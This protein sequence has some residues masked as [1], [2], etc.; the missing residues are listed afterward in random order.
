MIPVKGEPRV[1]LAKPAKGYRTWPFANDFMRHV[2]RAPSSVYPTLAAVLGSEGVTFYD[3]VFERKSTVAGVAKLAAQF[4]VVALGLVSSVLSLDMEVQI[5]AIKRLAPNTKIVL[6]GHQPTFYA[7]DWIARGVDAIIRSEGEISFPQVVDRFLAGKEPGGI[8]GVTWRMGEQAV[9]EPDCEFVKKLDDLPLPDW[10]VIDL[11]LYDLGLAPKGLT[12]T[13]ETARG[14]PHR[15]VFCASAAMWRNRQRFKSVERVMAEVRNLHERG[16]RQI[17]IADDNFGVY[18]ERDLE[19]FAQLAPLDVHLWAFVRADTIYHDREWAE[20][21]AKAG[22]R[23]ALIGFENLSEKM[24]AR[25]KKEQKGDLGLAEYQE[26]YR[27]LKKGGAFV[28]GLFVR[29]FDFSADDAW[30]AR[31]IATVCDVSAQSRF[32]PMRGVPG[33]EALVAQGYDLKDMFYH[34][35]FWPSFT[36]AGKVQS[37]HFVGAL[38]YDLLKPR[39]FFK[40]F[41]GSYVERVFFRRLYGG[42][43][44][45]F[46]RISPVRLKAAWIASRRRLS[47]QKRQERIIRL[48]LTESDR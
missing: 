38:V 37:S 28:Q 19:I 1:L 2:Y 46:L 35:R 39:N 7:D 3:G 16:V 25:Y 11:N 41:F 17:L 8:K 13:I 31:Q 22:L 32:I 47:P 24:L 12:G 23:L 5:R 30:P 48:V 21:A 18:R 27:R 15:C 44:T 29:D 34:D 45:D 4:P 26:V 20:A 36:R 42:L 33:A 9:E 43:L 14:C 6:G 10:S 40:M